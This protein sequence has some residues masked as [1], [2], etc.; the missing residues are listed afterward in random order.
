[1]LGQLLYRFFHRPLDPPTTESAGDDHGR[2][3]PN[4]AATRRGCGSSADDGWSSLRESKEEEVPRDIL[5][6]T[7][8]S[9]ATIEFDPG[10]DRLVDPF[11]KVHEEFAPVFEAASLSPRQE[12]ILEL[13]YPKIRT[14][15]QEVFD[16]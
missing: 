8:A 13:R 7:S 16:L 1:L 11:D 14:L 2:A 15:R 5:R 3:K 4:K 6:R 9:V 10:L 12:L